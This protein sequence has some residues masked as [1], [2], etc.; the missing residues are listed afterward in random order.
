M[1]VNRYR[2]APYLFGLNQHSKTT[3]SHCECILFENNGALGKIRNLHFWHMQI[4]AYFLAVQYTQNR[5][6]EA[7]GRRV[8]IKTRESIGQRFPRQ[9]VNLR[10]IG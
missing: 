7:S 10:G 3:R 6:R 2:R 4:G 5:L 9:P 8:T 1:V